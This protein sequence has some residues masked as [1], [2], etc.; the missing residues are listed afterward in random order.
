MYERGIGL[1][2]R[3]FD[4]DSFVPGRERAV[5]DDSVA[6]RE[7][8]VVLERR[9]SGLCHATVRTRPAGASD[10]LGK[11]SRRRRTGN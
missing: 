5:N 7:P 1:C 6:L 3:D 2:R 4:D 10:S 11:A 9:G 8:I